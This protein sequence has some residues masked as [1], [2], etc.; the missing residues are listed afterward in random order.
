MLIKIPGVIVD[1]STPVTTTP[2]PQP[3]ALTK[4]V[5]TTL[6]VPVTGSNGAALNLTGYTAPTLT[7]RRQANT[8]NLSQIVGTVSNPSGGILQFLIPGSVITALPVSCLFD[9]FVTNGSGLRDEPVPNSAVTVS[10]A[11]GA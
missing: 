11:A 6:Q 4:G 1:G 3:I 8:P 10:D 7:F 9:V 5:D 2:Q